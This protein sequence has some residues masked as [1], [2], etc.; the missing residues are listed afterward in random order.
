MTKFKINE[1]FTSIQGEGINTGKPSIF[2][3]VFGCD[4]ACSFCDSSSASNWNSKDYFEIQEEE[5]IDEILKYKDTI[6]KNIVLTGGNP[7]IYDFDNIIAKCKTLG[8][9]FEIE[10][11]GSK[12]SPFINDLDLITISPKFYHP[13][14]L[15]HFESFISKIEISHFSII[16]LKFVIDVKNMEEDIKKIYSCFE[17]Y[18]NDNIIHFNFNHIYI[19]FI[20]DGKDYDTQEYINKFNT[21]FNHFSK[22]NTSIKYKEYFSKIRF[23]V[24]LHKLLKLR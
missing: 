20:D 5:L 18:S 22:L 10:T 7:A 23:G 16:Q 2:I 6:F 24:Q 13:K 11:Q 19:H 15:E 14:F 17:I 12:F 4:Y 3:R 9:S 1:I 21:I 8:F